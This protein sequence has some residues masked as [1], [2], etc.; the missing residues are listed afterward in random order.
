M[1]SEQRIIKWLKNAVIVGLAAL[2]VIQTRKLW[3]DDIAALALPNLDIFSIFSDGGGGRRDNRASLEKLIVPKRILSASGAHLYLPLYEGIAGDAAYLTGREALSLLIENG[4]AAPRRGPAEDYGR[5]PDL[6]FDYGFSM[7]IEAFVKAFGTE[8]TVPGGWPDGFDRVYFYQNDTGI[9]VFFSVSGAVSGAFRAE[10]LTGLARMADRIYTAKEPGISEETGAEIKDIETLALEA[11]SP[12]LYYISAALLDN[13]LSRFLFFPVSY[14]DRFDYYSIRN[15]SPLDGSV[16]N[17]NNVKDKLG[18]YFDNAA[19]VR[20]DEEG[21]AYTFNDGHTV[22]RYQHRLLL[23]YSSWK[24][25]NRDLSDF[26]SAYAEAVHFLDGDTFLQNAYFLS[27][28]A[29]DGADYVFYFDYVVNGLPVCLSGTLKNDLKLRSAMEV[30]VSRDRVLRY[31]RYAS[32]FENMS[33]Q[34]DGRR[35]EYTE[36]A[37]SMSRHGI[38]NTHY[39]DITLLE[40][41]YAVDRNTRPALAISL[42]YDGAEIVTAVARE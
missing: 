34:P 38:T 14:P 19:A 40:L 28:Y 8:G 5:P 35:I 11:L 32:G 37:R 13:S 3:F 25:Q 30:T 41:A 26:A 23:E 29:L 33:S 22:V 36:A 9:D 27:D 17:I 42:E 18:G 7:P 4:A 15:I 31:R 6:V 10:G 20:G 12:G 2:C 24:P 16:V 39:S 21:G 1:G